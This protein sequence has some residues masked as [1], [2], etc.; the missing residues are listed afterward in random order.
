MPVGFFLFVAAWVFLIVIGFGFPYSP[1]YSAAARWAFNSFPWTLLAKGIG[2]LAATSDGH[3][4]G[5]QWA[6]RKRYCQVDTPS[7]QLQQLGYWQ[8]D[9]VTPLSE[10][11]VILGAQ[12]VVYLLLAIFVDRRRENSG[13]TSWSS[14]R[15]MF[16]KASPPGAAR[17]SDLRSDLRHMSKYL[18]TP[19]PSYR[20]E[21]PGELK[22][23]WRC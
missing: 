18:S 6:D 17:H 22:Q 9:C 19:P 7:P 10:I 14:W 23:R 20:G 4:E 8:T 15:A 5:M 21:T 3:L 2:D 12:T 11:Y 13:R 1:K 16:K